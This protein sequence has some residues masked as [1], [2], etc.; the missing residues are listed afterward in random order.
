MSLFRKYRTSERFTQRIM[1]LSSTIILVS[2]HSLTG[3]S[4]FAVSPT[5]LMSQKA[6]SNAK[7]S[8]AKLVF[9][10]AQQLYRQGTAESHRRSIALFQEAARLFKLEGSQTGEA[11][12]LNGIG[13]A[14]SALGEKQKS[15]EYFS[16]SLS[17]G[18]AAGDRIGEARTLH[19]I[20]LVYS[21]LGEK[22]K[23]LKF[24]DQALIISRS[25]GNRKEEASILGSI[26]NVY[27]ALGEKQKAL[28]YF[29]PALT[30]SRAVGVRSL[31]AIILSGIG[32][33]Y[34][35]L[36]EK[37]TALD[38]FDLA[39]T[40]SQALG[41]HTGEASIINKIGKVYSELGE[42]RRALDYFSQSLSICQA[43]GNIA[44]QA[45]ILK[46]IGSVFRALGDEQ[47]ALDYFNQALIISRTVGDH[48]QEGNILNGIGNIYSALGEKQKAL[49]YFNQAL[50]IR[51][52]VG[53]RAGEANTLSNIGRVYRALGE[54]QKA[55][56]YFNQA[57]PISRAVGARAE[58]ASILR[59]IAT[60]FKDQGN[61][62][63]ALDH[64][65]SATKIL[66][67][68]RSA[69]D[70]QDLRASYFATVQSYYQIQ[71]DLLMQL[72][73]N[74]SQQGYDRIALETSE[75]AR[76]RSFLELLSE[77]SIDPKPTQKNTSLFIQEHQLRQSLQQLEKQRFT[78]FNGK[79]TPAQAE[80]LTERSDVLV[81]Q[82]KDVA[83]R[84]RAQDPAYADIKYPQTLTLTQIQ[85]QVLDEN[86]VLLEYSLGTEHS[87]LWMVTR[88]T[89]SSYVL[90]KG[91]DIKAAVN[92]F[93]KVLT[94]PSQSNNPTGVAQASAPLSLMLLKPVASQLGSKRL[95][96]VSDGVL[97]YLPFAA[98]SLP[99]SKQEASNSNSQQAM[100][101]L[102]AE[103]EIVNMSSASTLAALRNE[104]AKHKPAAKSIAIFADPVFSQDDIRLQNKKPQPVPL[105]ALSTDLKNLPINTQ[106]LRNSSFRSFGRLTD[107]R[108]EAEQIIELVPDK[109]SE[110]VA[111]D[112]DANKE[113]A[114]RPNLNQY[115][116]VHFATH[117]IL[118]SSHPEQ[119]GIA[120][121]SIDKQGAYQDGTL[122]LIDIFNLNLSADLVV[123]SACQTA[124]GKEMQGEGLVGLTRGFM[125]AGTPRVLA[126]L[127]NVNDESTAVF[128]T[129]FYKALL[130]KGL[131]PAAALRAAQLELQKQERWK[132]PYYWAA[133]T[134]QGEWR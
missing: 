15:L 129:F 30:I 92:A 53:A 83:A 39:L 63:K 19:S 84:L 107:T 68:L 89:F 69:I 54:K 94:D 60:L 101:S 91:S 76:A 93:R 48:V 2:N 4:A 73:Q 74:S 45:H 115:R 75:R 11:R 132:S 3:A 99:S 51:R 18:R 134:L 22:Q 67:N 78:L 64:I 102:L 55:L 26:G 88:T 56:D 80:D 114:T 25:L 58:E 36:G 32:S 103:H 117:G 10:D 7:P 77:S 13:N 5:M 24:Y 27:G 34:D 100:P 118:D 49:D 90:P 87:Y 108:R 20:G 128:M 21:I 62:Q 126:S 46:N 1:Q 95:L 122:K 127:W 14:Y 66:D 38:Y 124:L 28:D 57:L 31:E 59:S 33:L 110:Y 12:A 6:T 113:N 81:Q 125:Y 131:P 40:I 44:I 133:F 52:A 120:L 98:L 17:L 72:H 23:A 29:N 97:H 121:S 37:Q 71:V 82:I 116:I 119:S 96:I 41:N 106:T 104:R 109:K 50:S 112:F 61:L 42:T 123:L 105:K 86:T 9:N 16:Q 79:Q 43:V 111:L 130:Q 35:D 47:K 70:D 8:P 65:Q 85:Q